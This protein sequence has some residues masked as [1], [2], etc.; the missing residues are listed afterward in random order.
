MKLARRW[1]RCDG[2]DTSPKRTLE[3]LA[4]AFGVDLVQLRYL[5]GRSSLTPVLTHTNP[6]RRYYSYRQVRALLKEQQ[7]AADTRTPA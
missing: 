4:E 5:V 2:T 1:G 6:T 3:E 7:V